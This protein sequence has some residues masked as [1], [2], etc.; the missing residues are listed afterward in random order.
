MNKLE[1]P[2]CNHSE[3]IEKMN[4]RKDSMIYMAKLFLVQKE[5][6]D[7]VVHTFICFACNHLTNFAGNVDG[8]IEYF[9]TYKYDKDVKFD[10]YYDI[11]GERNK[12]DAI[13]RMIID[14]NF[15]NN[16]DH[17]IKRLDKL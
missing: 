14:I 9:E 5:N 16:L 4:Y 1:C 15:D 3:I 10:N 11:H 17:F 6:P 7:L 2:N 13:K 8:T 12:F